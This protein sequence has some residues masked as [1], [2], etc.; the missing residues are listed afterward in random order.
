MQTGYIDFDDARYVELARQGDS[1]AFDILTTQYYGT[2]YAICMAQLRFDR[3]AA[4]ELAQ[5]V[6][7]RAY[8]NLDRLSQPAYFPAWLV[9]IARN[10]VAT[11]NRDHRRRSDLVRMIPLHDTDAHAVPDSEISPREAAAKH[12]EIRLVHEALMKMQTQP[13]EL[14]LLHYAEGLTLSQIARRLDVHPSTIMRQLDAAMRQLRGVW[15]VQGGKSLLPGGGK[16]RGAKRVTTLIV[17]ALALSSGAKSALVHAA[18]IELPPAPTSAAGTVSRLKGK[19]LMTTTA[20]AFALT[21]TIA[22]MLHQSGYF[23]RTVLDNKERVVVTNRNGIDSSPVQD[24]VRRTPPRVVAQVPANPSAVIPGRRALASQ[25]TSGTIGPPGPRN[26]TPNGLRNGPNNVMVPPQPRIKTGMK[27]AGRVRN[28]DGDPIAN[29]SIL[30]H[31]LTPTSMQIPG[32]TATSIVSPTVNIYNRKT[33]DLGNF[34]IDDVT[35]LS[36]SI[37]IT[38]TGYCQLVRPISM[39]GES[40]DLRL[41]R[42]GASA[43][44][45]VRSIVSGKPV[46]NI[47]VLF[48]PTVSVPFPQHPQTPHFNLGGKSEKAITD[49]NGQYRLSLLPT[50]QFRL[51]VSGNDFIPIPEGSRALASVALRDNETTTLP[52]LYVYQGYTIRGRV[53]DVRT[54]R[55]LEGTT[56]TAQGGMGAAAIGSGNRNRAAVTGPDGEFVLEHLASLQDATMSQPPSPP[57]ASIRSPLCILNAER[58]GYEAKTLWVNQDGPFDPNKLELVRDMDMEPVTSR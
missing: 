24:N 40:I 13:R 43:Q 15:N 53:Y 33:D 1:S 32:R 17:A 34:V 3:E 2:V 50:A 30:I 42:T 31:V 22:F 11:W 49:T 14:L 36:G 52:D 39:P 38:A 25:M 9:R 21:G 23:S 55:P 54:R 41:A 10:L 4:E 56:V 47:E 46:S 26:P 51:G 28:E 8:L 18:Q 27:F 35:T 20:L 45:T 48:Q 37:S 57:G 19:R 5:E 7:L 58:N 29:A 16:S 6:F 12:E 44:G